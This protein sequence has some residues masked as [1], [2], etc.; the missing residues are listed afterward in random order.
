[1]LFR[2]VLVLSCVALSL[3]GCSKDEGAQP[4]PAAP[5]GET[6]SAP[7]EALVEKQC[8]TCHTLKRVE[9]ANLD[10]A[11]WERTVDLMIDKGA[12][13][14]EAERKIVIDYLSGR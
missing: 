1:M 10:R 11:G 4:S 12:R 6:E 3:V 7:G 9:A 2:V 14:N 5:V 13:L 8:A